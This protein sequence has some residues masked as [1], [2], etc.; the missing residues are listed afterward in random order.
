MRTLILALVGLMV[1]AGIASAQDRW[2]YFDFETLDINIDM[3]TGLSGYADPGY[4][5]NPAVVNVAGAP[6]VVPGVIG[7]A[8]KFDGATKINLNDFE[9]FERAFSKETVSVYFNVD[10]TTSETE[11]NVF[12]IYEEGGGTNGM[13]LYVGNDELVVATRDAGADFEKVVSTPFTDAGNWHN[14]SIVYNEG[15]LSLFL[16]F[17]EVGSIDTE[18]PDDSG[19]PPPA[20]LEEFTYVKA[21]TQHTSNAAIGGGQGPCCLGVADAAAFYVGMIDEF[22]I[23]RD[24]ALTAEQLAAAV[25]SGNKVTSTWG[26]IKK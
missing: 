24:V 25:N 15:I 22:I 4:S 26:A 2:F 5:N 19:S 7:N 12:M 14:A 16:D 17:K 18:Y 10:A 21:I 20:G 6:E 3:L 13:M 1:F 9:A 23:F 8:W 11:G